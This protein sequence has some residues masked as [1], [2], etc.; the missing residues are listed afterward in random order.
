MEMLPFLLCK[1]E[2]AVV[3]FKNP[4]PPGI[5]CADK[6]LDRSIAVVQLHSGERAAAVD[7]KTASEL[8]GRADISGVCHGD[9]LHKLKGPRVFV[10][11][12]FIVIDVSPSVPL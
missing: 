8:L 6:C 1:P 7:Q 2:T 5:S 12:I 10:D 4:V 11:Q 3:V 9:L